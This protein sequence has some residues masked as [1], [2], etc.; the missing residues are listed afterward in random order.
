MKFDTEKHINPRTGEVIEGAN[1]KPQDKRLMSYDVQGI[2][3]V[4]P[5]NVVRN[6][7]IRE[8]NSGNSSTKDSAYGSIEGQAEKTPIVK[9]PYT[10]SPTRSL[11]TSSIKPNKSPMTIHAQR[12]Q[13]TDEVFSQEIQNMQG[14]SSTVN[15]FGNPA[16]PHRASTS[17]NNHLEVPRQKSYDSRQSSNTELYEAENKPI[18]NDPQTDPS[19]AVYPQSQDLKN[20]SFHPQQQ[21]QHTY[22]SLKDSPYDT[23]S[24]RNEINNGVDNNNGNNNVPE[25]P[26]VSMMNIVQGQIQINPY[27]NEHNQNVVNVSVTP[28]REKRY[29]RYSSYT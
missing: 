25:S 4:A 2:E 14:S 23:V 1:T 27:G 8:D 24:S 3:P 21:E 26:Y 20:Q 10:R 11:S 12:I 9:E 6:Y 22:V 18:K 7:G 19:H 13:K 17:A 28:V 15:S 29:Q 5:A 16:R